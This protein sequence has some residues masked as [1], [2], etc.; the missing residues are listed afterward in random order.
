MGGQYMYGNVISV[1]VV[2]CDGNTSSHAMWHYANWRLWGKTEDLLAWRGLSG[3]YRKEEI[4]L[5]KT[6]LGGKISGQ[7][8]KE[9]G[10]IQRLGEVYGA[11]AMIPGGWLYENRVKYGKLGGEA[12]VKLGVGA[13]CMPRDERV[14]LAKTIY[15]EGKGLASI[16]PEERVEISTRAGI[17]SGQLH[18]ERGTGVCGIPPEEHSKRVANTNKQKWKCPECS[19]IN[20]A[21]HVNSHMAETHGLPKN[22][23]LKITG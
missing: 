21:R 11:L 7:A 22:A 23:K 9:S 18:K 1:K 8:N 20:I 10:H 17:I 13:C 2:T 16:L 15:A 5:E 6:K 3:F 12:A 19:Y 14:A 4:I